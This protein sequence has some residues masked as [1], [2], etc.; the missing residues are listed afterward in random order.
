LNYII[1]FLILFIIG[2]PALFALDG[3]FATSKSSSYAVTVMYGIILT[4]ALAIYRG[5]TDREIGHMVLR[6]MVV[7]L[8]FCFLETLST[9]HWPNL[10]MIQVLVCLTV[11]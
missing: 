3:L 8:F 7:C 2:L 11:T 6:R 4:G 5:A 10:E 9:E 1:K